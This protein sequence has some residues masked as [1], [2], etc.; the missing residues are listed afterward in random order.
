MYMVECADYGNLD[1]ADECADELGTDFQNDGQDGVASNENGQ[2]YK[3]TS[4][5][6]DAA[7]QWSAS[8]LPRHDTASTNVSNDKLTTDKGWNNTTSRG[9]SPVR[10]EQSEAAPNAANG[11]A[12]LQQDNLK[13]IL[14]V[15]SLS[16]LPKL[17]NSE[18]P[19]Q[20]TNNST[21][22]YRNQVN[23]SQQRQR[24]AWLMRDTNQN[25]CVNAIAKPTR[26]GSKLSP[27]S[28]FKTAVKKADHVDNDVVNYLENFGMAQKAAS[29]QTQGSRTNC[30]SLRNQ[31]LK[32]KARF[33]KQTPFQR[34]QGPLGSLDSTPNL[35]I[36]STFS[37]AVKDYS[38][39]GP[40]IRMRVKTP[41]DPN[42]QMT[43]QSQLGGQN[44]DL[45]PLPINN[46]GQA[47]A[48]TSLNAA[49]GR[50]QGKPRKRNYNEAYGR[51][52]P[53]HPSAKTFSMGTRRPPI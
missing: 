49:M 33:R 39:W 43:I 13:G 1:V 3:D 12:A 46:E 42:L 19:A 11:A 2:R 52:S 14:Q 24:E 44:N 51:P 16:S 20:V 29:G 50:G 32:A 30:K 18:F 26:N 5:V 17:G 6:E 47:S 10:Q 40:S 48:S 31:R 45:Q 9:T 38:E 25:V 7:A 34:N 15:R 35:A 36:Q 37:P 28:S 21:V 22:T 27:N 23:L 8:N 41:Y 4:T 53:A